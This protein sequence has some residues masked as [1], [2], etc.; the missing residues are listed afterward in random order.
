MRPTYKV[1]ML[2]DRPSENGYGPLVEEVIDVHI[3]REHCSSNDEAVKYATETFD[4]YAT[5]LKKVI[6]VTYGSAL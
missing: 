2:V 6:S 1:T 3:Y 5:T 4:L